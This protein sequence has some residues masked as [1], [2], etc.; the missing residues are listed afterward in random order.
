MSLWKRLLGVVA[1]SAPHAA[2]R[3]R[4]PVP[5]PHETEQ[6]IMVFENTA[7]VIRAERLLGM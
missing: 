4:P 2:E 7:E 1:S 5:S 6:G 3:G